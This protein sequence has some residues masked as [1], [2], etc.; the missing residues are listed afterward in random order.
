MTGRETGI[1]D[2]DSERGKHNAM[3]ERA[4]HVKSEERKERGR[5]RE[6]KD[7]KLSSYSSL[8][9]HYIPDYLPKTLLKH[10]FVF[11]QLRLYF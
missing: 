11:I 7:D 5:E 4:M 1:G 10:F 6:K 9:L 3:K 2:N 8:I